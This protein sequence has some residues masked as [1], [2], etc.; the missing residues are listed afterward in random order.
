MSDTT[1]IISDAWN[2]FSLQLVPMCLGG[3]SLRDIK[4]ID[5]PT[6][7]MTPEQIEQY[8]NAGQALCG[9]PEPLKLALGVGLNAGL[10]MLALQFVLLGNNQILPSNC[11]IIN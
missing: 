8:M 10:L 9:W 11:L 6:A 3:P 5:D 4:P 1:S 2:K 7:G